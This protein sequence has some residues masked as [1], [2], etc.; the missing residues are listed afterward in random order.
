MSGNEKVKQNTA[1]LLDE[2]GIFAFGLSERAHGADLYSSEMM[3]TPLAEGKYVAD[4]GKYY[5]G[6]ANEAAYVSTFAK[7]SE[8]DEYVFFVADPRAEN[9]D[10]IKNTVDWSGVR[11]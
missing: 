6:N 10:L 1:R 7:N 8:T 9:Y 4:G 5:I 11:G 3:L 2:G